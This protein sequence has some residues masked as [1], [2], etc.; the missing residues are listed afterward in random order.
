[1][2]DDGRGVRIRWSGALVCL[3]AL[4]ALAGAQSL[5]EVAKK[6]HDRRDK[7]KK[8]G[9]ST[10]TFTEE[11]LA[12]TKGQ[13]A[14]DPRE[15]AATGAGGDA[16]KGAGASIAGRPR[17][18]VVP[19]DSKEEYWRGRVSEARARVEDAQRRSDALQRMIRVGQGAHYDANGRRVIYSIQQMKAMADAADAALASAQSALEN[20]LEE[21]RRAG[22]L[23]GWL[24]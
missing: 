20:V 10:R 4:P 21:G 22:A 16:S 18:D 2:T 14:N 5:G 7:L 8:T 9:V 15:Q 1:M 13:L 19:A 24:R 12:T 6:E 23:P 11:D 3:L 17:E